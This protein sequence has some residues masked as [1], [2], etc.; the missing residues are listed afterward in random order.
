MNFSS[1][2][3]INLSFFTDLLDQPTWGIIEDLFT[4][5]GWPIFVVLLFPAGAYFWKYFRGMKYYA[6]FKYV[7]LA[8]DVPPLEIQTP[9]AVEQIFAHLSGALRHRTLK[10][11]YW[12]GK[13]QKRFSFEIVSIEGYIQFLIRTE[14]EFR[15]LIEAAVYAQYPSA[16]ITEVEDYVSMIPDNYPN[17]DMDVQGIEFNLLE[18]QAYPIRTYPEFKYDIN[19]EITFSDPMAALL[20][21]FTRIGKGE[22][23][24]M[25]LVLIPTDNGWKENGI[26]LVKKLLG[27]KEKSTPSILNKFGGVPINLM[28]DA[29]K[30][31]WREDVGEAGNSNE[32]KEEKETITPGR[33]KVIEAVEQKISKIGF[34]S[35]IRVLYA[36]KKPNY[37]PQKCMSGIMGAINQFHTANTNALVPYASTFTNFE[38]KKF[39][40]QVSKNFFVKGYK[41]RKEFEGAS[42]F[43]LNIEEIATLWH[44]PMPFV[45]APLVQKSEGKRAEPP[46]DLPTDLEESPLKTR[47]KEVKNKEEA[48]INLPTEEDGAPSDLPILPN[49]MPIITDSSGEI[50]TD[51]D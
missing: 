11:K 37:Q 3:S 30:Y 32:D 1:G 6:S 20:E 22:H 13:F 33:R 45:K 23:L 16:E 7:M 24:W 48:P 49:E 44:F 17:D 15:D 31:G 38:F 4:I 40:P 27:E 36:A 41:G 47:R 18:D 43:I 35:K 39:S 42:P 8:V 28:S 26:K 10:E 29:I 5:I 50:K 46:T 19:P 12:D 14:A 51:A 34:E 9:K 21:T 25:Q 2:F